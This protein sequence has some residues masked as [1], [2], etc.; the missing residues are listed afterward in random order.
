VYY[1]RNIF[2]L[3][4]IASDFEKS[5]KQIAY[6]R[7]ADLC[8]DERLRGKRDSVDQ[9]GQLALM[10]VPGGWR[11]AWRI[12]RAIKQSCLTNLGVRRHSTY[13]L[14]I[15]GTKSLIVFTLGVFACKLIK[16]KNEWNKYI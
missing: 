8:H 3:D 11:T 6:S 14:D 7:V 12:I 5:L 13:L 2:L 10:R 1:T 9:Y 15:F 4:G 16:L